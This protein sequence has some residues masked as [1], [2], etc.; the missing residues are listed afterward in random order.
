MSASS[1]ERFEIIRQVASRLSF[2]SGIES[3]IQS[4]FCALET[5]GPELLRAIA[6][7]NDIGVLHSENPRLFLGGRFP[8][9]FRNSDGMPSIRREFLELSRLI[10]RFC[11]E[12]HC[13]RIGKTSGKLILTGRLGP[14]AWCVLLIEFKSP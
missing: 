13:F 3:T 7:L 4:Q 12:S 6:G 1:F 9:S 2:S 14:D 5:I 8:A 10:Q 11:S